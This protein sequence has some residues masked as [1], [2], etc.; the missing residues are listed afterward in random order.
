MPGRFQPGHLLGQ[1]AQART[2]LGQR[3]LARHHAV[4]EHGGK[5]AGE[6]EGGRRDVVGP[7]AGVYLYFQHISSVSPGEASPRV[8][9]PVTLVPTI[10]PDLAVQQ[11]SPNPA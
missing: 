3:G 5:G 2:H 11:L 10:D 7:C 6:Y 9:S 4:A 8:T 1:S